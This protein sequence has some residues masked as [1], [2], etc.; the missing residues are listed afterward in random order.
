MTFPER[1]RHFA[2]VVSF[3]LLIATG[4]PL[5]VFGLPSDSVK[6]SYLRG[7]FHRAAA[8]V[9]ILT[10]VWRFLESFLTPRGRDMRRARR[11]RI[12]DL[13]DAVQVFGYNLGIT[14]FLARKG[15]GKTL[16]QKAPV[17]A[18]RR[19]AGLRPV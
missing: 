9:L 7:L 4:L 19:A 14:G 6:R 3:V 10:L 8:V 15:I 5:L 18:V 13:R 12:L 1:I 11:L 16:L 2:L 17:L